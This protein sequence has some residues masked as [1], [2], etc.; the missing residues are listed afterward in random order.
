MANYL[1]IQKSNK[2][3]AE[4]RSFDNIITKICPLGAHLLY[5]EVNFV[6]FRTLEHV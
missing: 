1:Y 4:V 6:F 3:F 2:I 5:I